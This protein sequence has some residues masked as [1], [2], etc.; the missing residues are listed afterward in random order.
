MHPENYG[1]PG[2]P[3]STQR[4][5]VHPVEGRDS[6]GGN[7]PHETENNT[8]ASGNK[9]T[10][11][12]LLRKSEV[13]GVSIFT[14]QFPLRMASLFA[15]SVP[16]PATDPEASTNPV[17]KNSRNSTPN[18]TRKQS[19]SSNPSSPTQQRRL[20]KEILPR[21]LIIMDKTGKIFNSLEIFGLGGD[22]QPPLPVVQP[23]PTTDENEDD[24]QSIVSSQSKSKGNTN[25][26]RSNDSGD[27]NSTRRS[28]TQ[29]ATRPPSTTD[30]GDIETGNV[31]T[32]ENPPPIITPSTSAIFQGSKFVKEDCVI[33]LTEPKNIVLLPCR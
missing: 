5:M 15:S 14:F 1:R 11:I 27:N 31:K 33:C 7:S 8:S 6:N 28:S 3:P 30:G 19:T 17:V 23:A 32:E 4:V 2:S 25:R 10:N 18:K 16:V 12:G 26:T 24:N 21:E 29:N 20:M 9:N 22:G 13:T